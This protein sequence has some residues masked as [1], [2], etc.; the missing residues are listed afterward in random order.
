MHIPTCIFQM[1]AYVRIH[2]MQ[3]HYLHVFIYAHTY[4]HIYLETATSPSE[5]NGLFPSNWRVEAA[6]VPGSAQQNPQHRVLLCTEQQSMPSQQ[7][8]PKLLISQCCAPGH[9]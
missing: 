1:C 5:I 7:E 3:I 6:A 2:W 8:L 4:M 9:G